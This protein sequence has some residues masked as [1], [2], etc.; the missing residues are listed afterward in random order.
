MAFAIRFAASLAIVIWGL[1]AAVLGLLRGVTLWALI[2]VALLVVGLPIVASHP[3]VR[4]SASLRGAE[5]TDAPA[6]RK[7]NS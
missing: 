6:S 5:A 4:L 3:W 2:G 1:A 7:D